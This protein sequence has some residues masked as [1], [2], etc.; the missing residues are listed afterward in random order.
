M[1]RLLVIFA[2]LVVGMPS[3][4][5]A[6]VAPP[7]VAVPRQGPDAPFTTTPV[8][9]VQ[10]FTDEVFS[11]TQSPHKT[12]VDVPNVA[13]NRIQ[14]EMSARPD[15]DPWDRLFGVAVAGAEVLRGTT[16]RAPFTVRREI[17]DYS[18]A[19]AAGGR[20]EVSLMFSTYVGRQIASVTLNFYNEDSPLV[21]GG[22]GAVV[23][24]GLWDYLGRGTHSST[25][26]FPDAVAASATLEMTMSGHGAEEFWY[27]P[28]APRRFHV[29]VD[30][31]EIAVMTPMPYVYALVGFD[32]STGTAAH[33]YM[34]WTAQRAADESGVHTGVGQ[35]PSYRASIPY[36][37]MSLLRG[38]RNVSVVSDNSGDFWVTSL[39]FLIR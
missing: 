13:F 8:A 27:L 19:L 31:Q 3:V 37:A 36:W 20:A 9:V 24:A 23:G 34:W 25:V 2:L 7:A 38:S 6:Q 22:G 5:Q 21:S 11:F 29:L 33:P 28:G 14:V 1:R 35:I 30:G 12:V 39:T 32:G 15:G 16:P 17:T 4:A 10:A 18:A 26:G